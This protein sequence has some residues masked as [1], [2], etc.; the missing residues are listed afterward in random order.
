MHRI[1]ITYRNGPD[2]QFNWEYYM[3]NHLPLAVGTSRR[4][5]GL[6]FCD[7]DRPVADATPFVCV[8]MVHFDNEDT[9][10]DFCNFFVKEHPESDKINNDEINYTNVA[11]DMVAAEYERPESNDQSAEISYRIKL[12]FPSLQDRILSRKE[13]TKKLT[14]FLDV[15][16]PKN[17][18][19]VSTE[20]DFCTSGIVPGSE[21]D[22]SLIW[23]I[24]FTNKKSAEALSEFLSTTESFQKLKI[25]M[26]IEPEIILSK[27]MPFDIAL[28]EPY[29]LLEN[30]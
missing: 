29:R 28:S 4:H 5:S 23:V 20:F 9:M 12:F 27:V 6:N 1:S 18:E 30:P 24:N 14:D 22:F 25:I 7:A 8:C 10:N 17:A 21:P 3:N 15:N 26:N 16:A 19:I 11:P 13:I 2:A